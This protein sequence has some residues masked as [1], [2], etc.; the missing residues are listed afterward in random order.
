M[1]GS[2]ALAASAASGTRLITRHLVLEGSFQWI[3]GE[4]ITSIANVRQLDGI[5]TE[6]PDPYTGRLTFPLLEVN[7]HLF[8]PLKLFS[9]MPPNDS[10]SSSSATACSA[11]P[12]STNYLSSV[13]DIIDRVHKH[14]YGHSSYSDHCLLLEC[15]GL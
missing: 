10:I 9:S 8:S 15:N 5:S 11:L 7:S 13:R 2:V 12:S 3:L 14:T 6:T 4:N 1:L